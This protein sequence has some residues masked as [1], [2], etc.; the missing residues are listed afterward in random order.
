M[1]HRPSEPNPPLLRFLGQTEPFGVLQTTESLLRSAVWGLPGSQLSTP[2]APGKWSVIEV[3]Q[4]L[5]DCE[6][7]FGFR[8]RAVVAEDGPALAALDADAWAKGLKYRE[9]AIEEALDEFAAGRRANLR[10]LG[11]TTP[12][13]RAARYG[14]HAERGRESLEKMVH[15]YAAHDLCHLAQIERIKEAIAT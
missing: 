7:S 8:F 5:A 1:S 3:V 2:E 12:E 6:V 4:H 15:I 10:A 11:T 14:I 13:D 9:R